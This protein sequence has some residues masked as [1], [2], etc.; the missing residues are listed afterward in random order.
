MVLRGM[1]SRVRGRRGRI[2]G[3]IVDIDIVKCKNFSLKALV[4]MLNV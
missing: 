2:D 1:D 4:Y 3:E